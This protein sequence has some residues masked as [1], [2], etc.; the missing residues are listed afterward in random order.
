MHAH[1]QL[2]GRAA[3]VKDITEGIIHIFCNERP[4]AVCPLSLKQA[5]DIT[6]E[7]KEGE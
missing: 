5:D 6:E 7:E 3:V 4:W 1:V 2:L